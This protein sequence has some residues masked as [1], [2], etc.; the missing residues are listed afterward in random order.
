METELISFLKQNPSWNNNDVSKEN[1][2][3]LL[4]KELNP[5]I[6]LGIMEDL[7]FEFAGVEKFSEKGKTGYLGIMNFDKEKQKSE[8]LSKKFILSILVFLDKAAVDTLKQGNSYFIKG[9]FKSFKN[10]KYLIFETSGGNKEIESIFFP[11][12][13][14]NAT[15]IRRAN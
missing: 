13:R 7:P 10:D 9:D 5:K 14:I 6:K 3:Q 11:M 12:T 1:F 2:Y 15:E 4:S 8:S